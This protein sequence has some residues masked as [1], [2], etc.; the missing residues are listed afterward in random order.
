MNKSS[1]KLPYIVSV[2]FC[3]IF[4]CTTMVYAKGTLMTYEGI[5][6]R[7]KNSVQSFHLAAKTSIVVSHTTQ[8]F[9]KWIPG[10]CGVEIS[11]RMKW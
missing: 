1:I 3:M 7:D 4:L 6:I 5:G 8:K 2:I 9:E 10:D 11:L